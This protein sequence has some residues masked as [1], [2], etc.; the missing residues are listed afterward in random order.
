MNIDT[1]ASST[2]LEWADNGASSLL[3]PDSL[4]FDRAQQPDGLAGF[5]YG[6]MFIDMRGPEVVEKQAIWL[7]TYDV[8]IETWTARD[9]QAR[10]ATR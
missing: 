1:I 7:V 5:P 6:R 8:R 4:W 9:S 10:Q 2:K 3:V